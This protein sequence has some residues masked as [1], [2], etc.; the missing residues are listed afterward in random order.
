MPLWLYEEMKFADRYCPGRVSYY[1]N[2]DML[3][4][5][6]W[7]ADLHGSVGADAGQC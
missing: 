2:M 7:E 4:P 1:V 6:C 5:V 3:P